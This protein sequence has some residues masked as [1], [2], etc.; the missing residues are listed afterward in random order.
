MDELLYKDESKTLLGLAMLLHRELGCGFKEIIYQDAYEVLL[1]EHNI[2]YE[3]EKHMKMVYHGIE[4]K[5]DYYYDF[6]CYD[7]TCVEV[8]ANSE[9]FGEYESQII[10]Y[11]HI[12]NLRLGL[13]LNFGTSSL[14]YKFYPNRPD[15]KS[16]REF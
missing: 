9:I 3:R 14:Q 1:K 5:H 2:P 6:L 10:N 15:Y 7:K 13:L 16:S 8:K 12:G 11:I 4:L